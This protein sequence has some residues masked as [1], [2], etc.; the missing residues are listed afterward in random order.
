MTKRINKK[1]IPDVALSILVL[2]GLFTIIC[3]SSCGRDSVPK[4]RGQIRIDLPEK[5][6]KLFDTVFP[7]TFEYPVYAE[8]VKASSVDKHEMYKRFN[9]DIPKLKGTIH[10]TYEP[11]MNNLEILI[12]DAVDFV[13][14]H[15]PKAT[16]IT[17]SVV[18]RDVEPVYGTVFNIQG[19]G[20]ASTYQFYVT[21]STNHFMRGAL[22]LNTYT[23]NDSLRPVVDF[24]KV[25]VDHFIKTIQWK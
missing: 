22:Y 12:Q 21:D 10:L 20:A 7:Y 9:I 8:V 23:D 13:Y 16:A 18:E 17:K 3:L 11:V 19:R 1:S 5:E 2:I 4:P 14:K 25:D 15:V 24:L 6:Y